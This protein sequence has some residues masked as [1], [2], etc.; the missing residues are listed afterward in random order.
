MATLEPNRNVY[1]GHRYVPKIFGE[2]D[3]QVSYEGL[4]IVTHEGASFTSKKRVPL[5]VDIFNEEYWVVTGNY[6]AQIEEYRKDVRSVVNGLVEVT[7]EVE[8][9]NSDIQLERINALTPPEPLVGLHGDGLTDD[10]DRLQDLIDYARENNMKLF[11][12]SV[13]IVINKTIY[14][15]EHANIEGV[16]STSWGHVD[17]TRFISNITNGMPV[18]NVNGR[19]V[20]MCNFEI[21]GS[22]NCDGIKVDNRAFDFD[23]DN[24]K[25]KD[26]DTNFNILDA[27]TYQMT[28]C[29]TE[30][31]NIGFNFE[32]GTSANISG[33]VS[34]NAKVANFRISGLTY[35]T[36]TSCGA[37]GGGKG[38]DINGYNR[39]VTFTSFGC[40]NL[41]EEA[42]Y[43]NDNLFGAITFTAP[44]V[45]SASNKQNHLISINGTGQLTI[46]D[47]RLT[48][49]LSPENPYKIFNIPAS[50]A[51]VTLINPNVSG[52][53]GN[54][55][56]V[57]V[58]GGYVQG[59]NGSQLL[60]GLITPS[61]NT[62]T[63]NADHF[64]SKLNGRVLNLVQDVPSE[65]LFR[66]ETP[67]VYLV[68][69]VTSNKNNTARSSQLIF[70]T[71]NI[72]AETEEGN[73]TIVDVGTP[74]GFKFVND[75]TNIKLTR[76]T[77]GA[78]S[79]YWNAFKLM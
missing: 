42:I 15:G 75:G 72:A 6:N 34:F 32:Q 20:R 41:D 71:G 68:T 52:N 60:N 53:V 40:E 64:K 33:C 79:A 35:T 73:V 47:F 21:I 44:T 11:I 36:F 43:T 59:L 27:W 70:T 18:I 45:G 76:I 10:S 78:S 28:K 25:V 3:K 37:D 49:D 74:S 66:V 5:G 23:F 69:C 4:S 2:W 58:I 50:N 63:V 39:G 54:I 30:G 38:L 8:R 61:I 51:R 77:N 56:K 13:T 57:N 29:R 24:I 55:D 16:Y 31:G 12:P 9:V 46:T 62:G 14:T 1:V 48:T 19:S 7:E 26:C 65:T 17:G 67:S 22:E